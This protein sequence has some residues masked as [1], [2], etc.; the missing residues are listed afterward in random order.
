MGLLGSFIKQTINQAIEHTTGNL[1]LILALTAS[2]GTA[3]VVAY[4]AIVSNQAQTAENQ[5]KQEA[6][7]D[8]ANSQNNLSNQHKFNSN[9]KIDTQNLN[10]RREIASSNASALAQSP[11]TD[12]SE[13]VKTDKINSAKERLAANSGYSSGTSAFNNNGSKTYSRNANATNKDVINASNKKNSENGTTPTDKE[14]SGGVSNEDS[15]GNSTTDNSSSLTKSKNEPPTIELTT[16]TGGQTIKGNKPYTLTWTAT[17]QHVTKATAI[18]I[19]FSSDNGSSWSVSVSKIANSG[20][21]SW[22]VPN[23]SS[24]T[25]LV[26]VSV[27]DDVACLPLRNQHRFLP[28]IMWHQL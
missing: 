24:A 27:I 15:K 21:Y 10:A 7:S 14:I 20:T 17:G 18:N 22:N 4:K 28:S 26:R 25:C 19:E 23:V 5:T 2:G 8:S 9:N 1:P 12:N 11:S 3:S 16:L 13:N 6:N